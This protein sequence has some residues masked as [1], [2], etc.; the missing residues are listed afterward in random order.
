MK[1]IS[2][3]LLIYFYAKDNI[4]KNQETV[5]TLEFVIVLFKSIFPRW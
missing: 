1:P 5:T 2:L 4:I 3:L